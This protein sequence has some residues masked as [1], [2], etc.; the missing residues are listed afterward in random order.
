M[1]IVVLPLQIDPV[2]NDP[3]LLLA[4]AVAAI[5][6]AAARLGATRWQRDRS[7]PPMSMTGSRRIE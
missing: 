2:Q 6:F 4:V 3:E 7:C 1:P 5:V